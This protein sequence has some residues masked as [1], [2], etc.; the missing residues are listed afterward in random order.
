VHVA[1]HR[2]KIWKATDWSD[3]PDDRSYAAT[4]DAIVRHIR[5]LL[6]ELSQRGK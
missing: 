6:D 2:A 3:V 5:E 4:R 1:R